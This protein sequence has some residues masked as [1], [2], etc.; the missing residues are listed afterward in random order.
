MNRAV[1]FLSTG[2]CGTQWL[3]R[4][5]GASYPDCAVVEHEPLHDAYR[6]SELLVHRDLAGARSAAVIREHVSKIDAVL[7]SR[8]YI[9]C[10]WPSWGALPYLARHFVGRIAIVHLTRH[11]IPT[12]CSLVTH[13]TY[14]PPVIPG[15]H[16]EKIPLSPFDAGVTLPEYREIWDTLDPFQRC[17]YFWT[18]LHRFGLDLET[19]LG[20]EFATPW[21]RLRY[22]DMMTPDGLTR[23]LAFLGLAPH[24]TM[25]DAITNH[26]DRF[27]YLA[28]RWWDVSAARDLP[29]LADTAAALGYDLSDVDEAALRRRYLG[30]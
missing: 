3:A 29:G 7:E 12:A 19:G 16:P 30:M 5:L 8:M 21:L 13:G 2:R 15:L 1:F 25:F 10:G 28:D 23:L 14:Q 4:N 26:E 20:T 18:E 6:S 22:E 17:L 11:P 24:D 9:E 27:V